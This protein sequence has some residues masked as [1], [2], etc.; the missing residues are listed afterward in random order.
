MVQKQQSA[1]PKLSG[2]VREKFM[3][4]T[5]DQ[6][7]TEGFVQ[8]SMQ[9]HSSKWVLQDPDLGIKYSYWEAPQKS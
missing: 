6:S 1:R 5:A 9:P 7:G 2:D 4:A 8:L 3:K